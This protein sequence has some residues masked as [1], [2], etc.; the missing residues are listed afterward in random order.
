MAAAGESAVFWCLD[1]YKVPLQVR[2]PN[3]NQAAE[4]N[5][6]RFNMN[7]NQRFALLRRGG[8]K[9]IWLPSNFP[10]SQRQVPLIQWELIS[11]VP[12]S[13][14]PGVLRTARVRA[15]QQLVCLYTQLRYFA[16]LVPQKYNDFDTF[17][18]LSLWLLFLFVRL[19]VVGG[20]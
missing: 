3:F 12:L 15:D 11:T 14:H 18:L 4:Y 10:V 9:L 5:Y 17:T 7:I 2:K 8:V 20:P 1:I 13:L 16:K 19:V 6:I